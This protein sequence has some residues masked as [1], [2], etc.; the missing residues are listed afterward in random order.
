M[1]IS[2]QWLSSYQNL[3]NQIINMDSQKKSHISLEHYNNMRHKSIFQQ[4]ELYFAGESGQLS[5]YNSGCYKNTE[6]RIKMNKKIS[7]PL[8]E[9]LGV[10]QGKI[11]SSDHYKIYINPVLE[12]LEMLTWG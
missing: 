7:Q 2:D 4:R 11:R 12:T 6:T 3:S 10:G 8:Y 9:N 5:Q 1:S